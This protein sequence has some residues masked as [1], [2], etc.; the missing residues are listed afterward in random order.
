[1]TCCHVGLFFATAICVVAHFFKHA[2]WLLICT[3]FLPALAAAV[4]V[5]S[6]KLE[7][8]RIASQSAATESELTVMVQAIED[9]ARHY[10]WNGW[11]RL[12]ELTVEAARIMSDENDQWQQL[13]RHQ[14]T[15][16]PA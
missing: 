5:L 1:M 3:A 6:T 13:I 9:A 16:L 4:H 2:S 10:R 12:R 11:V 7:I 8:E 14:G 15:D